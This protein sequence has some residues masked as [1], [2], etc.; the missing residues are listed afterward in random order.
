MQLA[1]PA[2]DKQKNY[3]A[4]RQQAAEIADNFSAGPLQIRSTFKLHVLGGQLNGTYQYR[5]LSQEEFR[6]EIETTNFSESVVSRGGEVYFSRTKK[7]EPL[8]ISYLRELIYSAHIMPVFKPVLTVTTS[9][10]NGEKR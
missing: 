6:E 10:L 3:E 8:P 7:L 9:V 4:A 2:E 5:Q 1:F